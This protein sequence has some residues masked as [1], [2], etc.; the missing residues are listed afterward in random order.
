MKKIVATVVFIAMAYAN[1]TVCM[2]I[3]VKRDLTDDLFSYLNC[4][5]TIFEYKEN[6]CDQVERLV[7]MGADVNKHE[8]RMVSM[9]CGCTPLYKAIYEKCERCVRVLVKKA[10]FTI[11]PS[12]RTQCTYIDIALMYKSYKAVKI[13]FDA[14]VPADSKDDEHGKS[15]LFYEVQKGCFDGVKALLDCAGPVLVTPEILE[16]ASG[17]DNK[18]ICA[19]LNDVCKK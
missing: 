6:A 10:D 1:T 15:P 9:F 5:D 2:E 17:L 16:K 4:H 13:L 11:F 8:K 14:G 12:T 19:L 7:G 18:S 3:V